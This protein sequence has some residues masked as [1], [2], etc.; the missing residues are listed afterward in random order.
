MPKTST[1]QAKKSYMSYS[2]KASPKK[3]TKMSKK[4]TSPKTE[5]KVIPGAPKHPF[6][7]LLMSEIAV[8]ILKDQGVVPKDMKHTKISSTRKSMAKLNSEEQSEMIHF[9]EEKQKIMS[10]LKEKNAD[11]IKK[12]QESEEFRKMVKPGEGIPA[13]EKIKL[14]IRENAGF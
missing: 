10:V 2:P 8:D 3:K 13:S 11:I 4:M 5:K 6:I 9:V 14:E 7:F 12:F 1:K